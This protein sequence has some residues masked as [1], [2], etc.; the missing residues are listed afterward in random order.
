VHTLTVTVSGRKRAEATND[1]VGV[2][3]FVLSN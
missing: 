3:N 1:I 2:S